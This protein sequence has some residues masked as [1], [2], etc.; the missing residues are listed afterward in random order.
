MDPI[1]D[2]LI[3]IKNGGA[4]GKQTVVIPYSKF[5]MAL[6][7]LLEKNGYLKKVEQRGRKLKKIIEAEILYDKDNKPVVSDVSRISKPS[8]R[9]YKTAKEITRFSRTKGITIISTP[10]GLLTANEAK[11]NNVGGEVLCRVW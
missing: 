9:I 11:K 10:E 7:L 5:K 1:A 3:K 2:M 4:A 6:A 8:R